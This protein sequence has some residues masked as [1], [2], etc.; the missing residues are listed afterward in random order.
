MKFP[1]KRQNRY[2]LCL[3]KCQQRPHFSHFTTCQAS[4]RKKN[5]KK[6]K[7]A[8]EK[9]MLEAKTKD[10]QATKDESSSKDLSSKEAQASSDVGF[11]SNNARATTLTFAC[12]PLVQAESK[13]RCG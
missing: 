13:V 4:K 6:R 12:V 11:F 8:K 2:I 7:K 1:R 10:G 3:I 5:A 9:K